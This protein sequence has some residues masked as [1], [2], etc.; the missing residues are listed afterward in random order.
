MATHQVQSE[1]ASK[2]TAAGQAGGAPLL[3]DPEANIPNDGRHQAGINAAGGSRFSWLPAFLGFFFLTLNSATAIVRSRGDAAA[4]AF[5][6]FSYADLVA[7]FLCL[8]MYERAP[9]G[10][11]ARKSWLKVVVW[12]L[13][14]LL[15][16][17]FSG[18]VAAVMPPPVAV[19]V[20]L[21]AFATVAGG[22][23]A[24][25]VCKEKNGGTI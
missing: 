13:T 1:I 11:N 20:W 2:P 23:V 16:L 24:F 10:S 18:K 9:A 4:V 25:F 17:A 22:F 15:T 21:M 5:V 8:R 6:C 3:G 14:T 12:V 19:V 7:L